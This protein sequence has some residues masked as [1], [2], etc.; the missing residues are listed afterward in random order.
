[1]EVK[2]PALM[3]VVGS[4][5]MASKNNPKREETNKEGTA[6]T[7]EPRRFAGPRPDYFRLMG[8]RPLEHAI[9]QRELL[10]VVGVKDT[11]V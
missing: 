1:M 4:R 11:K 9:S 3:V 7:P 5:R 2:P 6:S 8:I 10:R